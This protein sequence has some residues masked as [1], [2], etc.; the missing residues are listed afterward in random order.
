MVHA[1]LLV[2]E[3]VVVV[4]AVTGTGKLSQQVWLMRLVLLP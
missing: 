2:E 4:V 1:L 3:V